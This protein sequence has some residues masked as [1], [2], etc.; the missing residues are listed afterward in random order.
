MTQV[1]VRC[2]WLLLRPFTRVNYSNLNVQQKQLSSHTKIG[3]A[4]G[5]GSGRVRA[6]GNKYMILFFDGHKSSLSSNN[7]RDINLFYDSI[8]RRFYHI[9]LNYD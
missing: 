6:G 2:G 8:N 9:S 5:S 3:A 7:L 4:G 1:N